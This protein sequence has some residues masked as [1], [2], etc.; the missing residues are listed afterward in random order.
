[1]KDN[2]LF[3]ISSLLFYLTQWDAIYI[4]EFYREMYGI[5]AIFIR[6][7]SDRKTHWTSIGTARDRILAKMM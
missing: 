4:E 1:M 6:D 7:V 2:K 3:F 5:M